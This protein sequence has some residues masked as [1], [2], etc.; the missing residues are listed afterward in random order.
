MATNNWMIA[1][2]TVALCLSGNSLGFQQ[3]PDDIAFAVV[4]RGGTAEDLVNGCKGAENVDPVMKTVPGKDATKVGFCFGYISGVLDFDRLESAARKQ[5]AR[6]CVPDNASS[7]QLAKVIVKYGNDHPEELH[8]PA[9]AFV[10]LAM[11]TA[12]PCG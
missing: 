1:V 5:A 4:S 12:F 7:S 9:V 3:K 8:L 6:Y 10:G 2:V 11:I